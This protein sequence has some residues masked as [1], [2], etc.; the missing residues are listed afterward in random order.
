MKKSILVSVIT[1][2]IAVLGRAQECTLPANLQNG[3]V[4]YWP[5][6]ENTFDESANG[7]NGTNNGVDFGEDRFGNLNSAG[8]FDGNDY[9]LV[10]NA[11]DQINTSSVCG[12]FNSAAIQGAAFV[13]FGNDNPNTGCTGMSIGQGAGDFIGDGNNLHAALNCTTGWVTGHFE[14]PPPG[15]WTHFAMVKAPGRLS[16]FINGVLVAYRIV[17]EPTFDLQTIFSRFIG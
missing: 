10:E 7:N 14:L 17:G 15:T 8:V 4:G 13:Q 5:F 11:I 16:L 1:V 6:N 12:W 2:M 9:V 3:L